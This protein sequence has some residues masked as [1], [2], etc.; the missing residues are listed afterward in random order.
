MFCKVMVRM[1][2]FLILCDH[3]ELKAS[4]RAVKTVT[5]PDCTLPDRGKQKALQADGHRTCED[6]K[7]RYW[8]QKGTLNNW[9]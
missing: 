9:H 6:I 7:P 8:E 3:R 2:K 1:H 5:K 4:G